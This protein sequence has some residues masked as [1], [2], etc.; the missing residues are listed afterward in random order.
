VV[1]F[2]M[3]RVA[4]LSTGT[5]PHSLVYAGDPIGVDDLGRELREDTDVV[6]V[7][8]DECAEGWLVACREVRVRSELAPVS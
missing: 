1:V 5:R 3:R 4:A 2:K 8:V 7:S 6:I